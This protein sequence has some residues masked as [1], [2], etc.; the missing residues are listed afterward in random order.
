MLDL[1]TLHEPATRNLRPNDDDAV[2][3]IAS[4]FIPPV[5]VP[6]FLLVSVI[7]Y[8]LYRLLHFGPAAFN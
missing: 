6:I 5:V 4:W 1:P 3:G 8:G 7:A 2:R